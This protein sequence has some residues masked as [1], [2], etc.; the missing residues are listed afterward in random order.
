MKEGCAMESGMIDLSKYRLE[1]AKSD[2]NV[3]KLLLDAAMHR[4]RFCKTKD[5]S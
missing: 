2:L 5:L 3:A 1:T 4:I